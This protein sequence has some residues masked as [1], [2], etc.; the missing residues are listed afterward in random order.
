MDQTIVTDTSLSYFI[1]WLISVQHFEVILYQSCIV[2]AVRLIVQQ[3]S[4]TNMQSVNSYFSYQQIT[5]FLNDRSVRICMCISLCSGL[6]K[7][8]GGWL[9]RSIIERLM[10]ILHV[11][12]WIFVKVQRLKTGAEFLLWVGIVINLILILKNM[13]PPWWN[14][15]N[16]RQ[17]LKWFPGIQRA[18]KPIISIFQH[19]NWL[20]VFI[21][22]VMQP[23]G[24]KN[25]KIPQKTRV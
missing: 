4:S 2:F 16:F 9:N 19:K 10:I 21:L 6:S 25:D 5:N 17:W 24:G 15:C 1:F 14:V 7:F 11:C 3:I 12:W 20:F 13:S 8:D 22:M 23:S 18:S